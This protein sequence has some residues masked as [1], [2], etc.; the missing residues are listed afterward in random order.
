MPVIP[1][2]QEA[3][4]DDPGSK[5]ARANSLLD[6]ISKK[7]FTRKGWW[8]GLRYRPRQQT[9]QLQKKKKKKKKGI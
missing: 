4:Q 8:S 5:P 6:P 1:A 7:A 9:P 2:T 3:D